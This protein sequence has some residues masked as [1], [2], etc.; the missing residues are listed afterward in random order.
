MKLDLA[1]ATFTTSTLG[2]MLR[3]ALQK[4]LKDYM[5]RTAPSEY[6]DILIP[7]FSFSTKRPVLD[8]GYLSALHYP[9]VKPLRSPSLTVVGPREIQTQ[10][11]GLFMPT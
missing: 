11:G 8:H 4:H 10:D 2:K 3:K 9:R 5:Q 7:D 6:H 1:F